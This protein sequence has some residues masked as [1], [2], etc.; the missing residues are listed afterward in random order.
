V[1]S[2][3]A[4]LTWKDNTNNETQFMIQRKEMGST[5]AYATVASPPFDT[6][7]YH[8]APLTAGKGRVRPRRAA[9]MI[10]WV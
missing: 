10:A 1:L 8:D 7:Q 2:G 4:H 3:G 5:A 6:S 9:A